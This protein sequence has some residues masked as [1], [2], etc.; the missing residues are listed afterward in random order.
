MSRHDSNPSPHTTASNPGRRR[1]IKQAGGAALGVGLMSGFSSLA[2]AAPRTIRIG[3]VTPRTGPLAPFAATDLFV[4]DQMRQK[5]LKDGIRVGNAMHPV[6]IIVKDSQSSTNRAATVA[7]DLI[8]DDQ[9]DLMLVSSTPETTNPV[10]D[11]CELNGVPCISTVAP[12]QPWFFTRGG[13]P[14]AG[15]QYTYHFFWGLED[16]IDVF[17]TMWSQLDTNQVVAGLWPND[18]DGNAWSD[19]E[20]GSRRYS[21][22]RASRSW[23]QDAIRT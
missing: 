4:I 21:R 3:Y 23:I 14:S 12:W 15:F 22:R 10:S 6:E 17:T 16:I 7:A 5:V 20:R 8:L 18:G 13:N 2:F 9:I 1:F 11:Q 19:A